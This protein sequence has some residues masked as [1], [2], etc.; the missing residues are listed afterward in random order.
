MERRV[1]LAITLSFLVLFLFQRFVMPPPPPPLTDPGTTTSPPPPVP[2]PGAGN[3]TAQAP[4]VPTAPT[5]VMAS[6]NATPAGPT[7]T[8]GDAV[9]R[10]IVVETTTVRAVFSNRGGRLLHWVLKE[11]RT[12]EGAPLDL[13]PEGAGP[14]AVKPFT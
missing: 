12:D 14:D 3:Q 5:N 8:V 1:L 6:G 13:V 4:V 9:E 11:Y 10:E 7:I 2:S